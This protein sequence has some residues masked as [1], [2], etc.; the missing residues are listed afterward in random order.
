[1]IFFLKNFGKE[2]K[3]NVLSYVGVQWDKIWL[4]CIHSKKILVEKQKF[5]ILFY[6]IWGFF[7]Q[8]GE[9]QNWAREANFYL[10]WTLTPSKFQEFVLLF[11]KI[12]KKFIVCLFSIKNWKKWFWIFLE[13]HFPKLIF[14]GL[15]K[16]KVFEK[17]FFWKLHNNPKKSRV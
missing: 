2:R 7:A 17:S 10:F 4:L 12:S 9:Y 5:F 8:Y 13:F 3:A 6:E 11:E 15:F 1:M 16:P 14:F